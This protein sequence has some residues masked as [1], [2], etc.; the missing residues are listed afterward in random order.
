MKANAKKGLEAAKAEEQKYRSKMLKD[1]EAEGA[2]RETEKARIQY[3]LMDAI[4]SVR[5]V[6]DMANQLKINSQFE[7]K[8]I[9]DQTPNG[10]MNIVCVQIKDN[11]KSGATELWHIEEFRTKFGTMNQQYYDNQALIQAGKKVD[12]PA[13]T[14]FRVNPTS[15]QVIGHAK[16]VMNFIYY[17]LDIED[18]LHIVSYT[19]QVAGSITVKVVPDWTNLGPNV[20]DVALTENMSEIQGIKHL[21]LNISIVSCSS[22]PAQFSS[23][24]R[25]K[26]GFPDFIINSLRVMAPSGE[27]V[28]KVDRDGDGSLDDADGTQRG[29]YYVTPAVTGGKSTV[30]PVI[31]YSSRIRVHNIGQKALNWFK[32]GDLILTVMGENTSLSKYISADTTASDSLKRDIA[33]LENMNKEIQ[34]MIKNKPGASTGVKGIISTVEQLTDDGKNELAQY[35]REHNVW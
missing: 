8:L 18:T 35:L 28:D 33:A 10:L 31:N 32:E 26:F 21:D 6:N 30:N 23:K 17:N 2:R 19:G 29:G 1:D 13:D 25:V 7:V 27:W 14:P 12:L 4:P 24:V 16:V 11:D 34:T 5:Q 22:L 15:A 20:T 9:S 3:D